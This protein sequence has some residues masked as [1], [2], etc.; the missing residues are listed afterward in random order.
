MKFLLLTLTLLTSFLNAFEYSSIHDETYWFI[1]DQ[2]VLDGYH[3]GTVRSDLVWSDTMKFLIDEK[4]CNDVPLL[5]FVFS[6]M[7]TVDMKAADKSFNVKDYVDKKVT[8][9]IEFDTGYQESITADIWSINSG[10][11]T[12]SLFIFMIPNM[13]KF[14]ITSDPEGKVFNQFMSL[15]VSKNDPLA[16]LFDMP[17]RSYRMGGLVPVWIAS[18][19]N[20]LDSVGGVSND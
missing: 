1:D 14:F 10:N 8:F 4:D 6:T 19:Q 15:S 9:D 11:P 12:L 16:Y 3:I 7:N 13:P 18:H 17:K 20:C 2:N 5:T